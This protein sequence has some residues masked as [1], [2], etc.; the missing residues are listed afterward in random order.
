MMTLYFGYGLLIFY[1]FL[2]V[3]MSIV[4][5]GM[6]GLGVMIYRNEDH[7]SDA[8]WRPV[9]VGLCIV[10]LIAQWVLLSSANTIIRTMWHSLPSLPPLFG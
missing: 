7:K 4:L 2:V 3:V 9:A 10:S 6:L 8:D 1:T 5:W